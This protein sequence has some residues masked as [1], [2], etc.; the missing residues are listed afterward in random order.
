MATKKTRL[1][2][3]KDRKLNWKDDASTADIVRDL[4][5][6]NVTVE[7][8]RDPAHPEDDIFQAVWNNGHDPLETYQLKGK[9]QREALIEAGGVT[10]WE[11]ARIVRSPE[12]QPGLSTGNF[13]GP[14]ARPLTPTD[15]AHLS[16]EAPVTGKPEGVHTEKPV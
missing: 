10:E 11:D 5:R 7:K 4:L 13:P 1:V 6:V 16:D 2:T 15:S 12:P 3:G 9:S 14:A 8:H